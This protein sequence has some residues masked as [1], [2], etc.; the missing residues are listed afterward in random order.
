[1]AKAFFCLKSA[2]L[3][4]IG[5]IVENN[6]G[7]GIQ[8]DVSAAVTIQPSSAGQSVVTHNSGNGV[9]VGDLSSA[10]FKGTPTVTGNGQPDILCNSPTA[11][12]RRALVAAGGAAHT[13][14]TN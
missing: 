6:A 5:C 8:V 9:Y 1:M 11:V 13:N 2:D 4:C 10:T 12:T 7:N 14:C 3:T